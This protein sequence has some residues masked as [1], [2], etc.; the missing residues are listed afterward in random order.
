MRILSLTADLSPAAAESVFATQ[1]EA[2]TIL[3][4]LGVIILLFEIGLE[5]DLKELLKVGPQAIIVAIVGLVAPFA[6]GTIGLLYIFN[7]PAIPAIFAGTALTATSIGITAKVLAE[8]GYLNSKEG[9]I[10][11]GAAVLDDIRGALS[12]T[13]ETAIIIMV[14]VTTFIPPPL[15]RVVFNKSSSESQES[16]STS[17]DK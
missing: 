9:Q 2:I 14:I 10:I 11:I 6:L 8:I 16:L 3:S 17:T 4:E 7:L 1:S 12:P 15:L 5:S 13:V